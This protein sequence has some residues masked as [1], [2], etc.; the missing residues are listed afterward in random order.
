[1][2]NLKNFLAK[3]I[4]FASKRVDAIRESHGDYPTETHNY[5]GGHSLGYWEG[6]LSAYENVLD[7]I[8]EMERV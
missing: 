5:S 2:N 7:L 3:R 4:T 1:M 8:E 6:K